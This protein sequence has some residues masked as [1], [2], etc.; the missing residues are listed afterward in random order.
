M[1][2]VDGAET[3]LFINDIG[4][5]DCL[6]ERLDG[7]NFGRVHAAIK[8]MN[9]GV[10]PQSSD[11]QTSFKFSFETAL[12]KLESAAAQIDQWILESKAPLSLISSHAAE[13][14]CSTGPLGLLDLLPKGASKAF[15]FQH[16]MKESHVDAEGVVFCGDSG[17]D[18][19]AIASG[20]NAVVV[21]NADQ[22][23]KSFSRALN[24]SEVYFSEA[25]STTGVPEGL[26]AHCERRANTSA[27]SRSN[28]TNV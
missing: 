20:V 27:S 5:Q 16:W 26:L 25:D 2:R 6:S 23:L 9:L 1:T 28:Q 8:Q 24:S 10:T 13:T 7:W 22:Q 12:P 4:Y 19:A 11:Q 21:G 17:N 3:N 15:A 18:S 14:E